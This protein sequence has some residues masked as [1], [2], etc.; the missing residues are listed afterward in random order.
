MVVSP[1]FFLQ[2]LARK[3]GRG[4]SL[5]EPGKEMVEANL[6]LSSQSRR[7]TYAAATSSRTPCGIFGWGATLHSYAPA[8]KDGWL[9]ARLASPVVRIQIMDLTR[10]RVMVLNWF[11]KPEEALMLQT[12]SPLILKLSLFLMTAV[13]THLVMSF[14]QTFYIIRS[15]TIQLAV[16][17]FAT[18]STSITPI[19]P[20]IILFLRRTSVTK[21]TLRPISLFLYF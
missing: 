11:V 19:M 3:A 6:R 14:G 20:T 2:V 17:C 9:D 21:A 4:Q 13:A 10:N 15:P 12:V 8:I 1:A 5:E 18:T 16:S 7:K